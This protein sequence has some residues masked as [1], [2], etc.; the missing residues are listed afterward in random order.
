[1]GVKCARS[2]KTNCRF[3]GSNRV[4]V[5]ECVRADPEVVELACKNL[6]KESF[7]P[8]VERLESASPSSM[9]Y[10]QRW[11][12]KSCCTGIETWEE[13][14]GSALGKQ[15]MGIGDNLGCGTCTSPQV[16]G[17]QKGVVDR[18]T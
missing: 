3:A 14:A 16:L 2:R 8:S 6:K 1:M 12:L 9:R 5:L 15:F 7:V 4:D 18:R 13:L 11:L 17:V 10:R